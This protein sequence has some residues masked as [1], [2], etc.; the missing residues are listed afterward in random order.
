MP[1]FYRTWWF[2]TIALIGVVGM[3][4]FIWVRRVAQ[5][6]LISAGQQA[7]ARQL[8]VSQESER[9]RI[10]AELHDGLGQHLVVIKNLALMFLRT[11]AGAPAT[12]NGALG[13]IEEISAEASHAIGEVKEISYNLRPYQLDRIGL[14]KAVEALARTSAA[15]SHIGFTAEIDNIDGFF[16]QE[17]EINFYRIVQESVNNIV[18]H[19]EATLASVSVQRDPERLRLIIRDNGKGFAPGGDRP[20]R[21]ATGFGLIGIRERVQ[22]LGGN[23]VIQSAPGRGTTMSIEIGSRGLRHDR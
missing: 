13:Q 1:P 8:I 12:S 11:S 5:L 19:S 9:K 3:V 6:K 23:T 7:F 14:T 20:D 15:C 10:A 21:R 22:L 4:W 2:V 17:S 18:K 16:P